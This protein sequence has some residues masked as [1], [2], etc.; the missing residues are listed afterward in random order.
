MNLIESS[1]DVTTAKRAS[2][3]PVFNVSYPGYV[4]LIIYDPANS[5]RVDGKINSKSV[6][7]LLDTGAAVSL[8][9]KDIWDSL[10]LAVDL[11]TWSS[12][13]QLVGVDGSPLPVCGCTQIMLQLGGAVEYAVQIIVIKSLTPGAILGLDF[14]RNNSCVIDIAERLQ[15]KHLKEEELY[16]RKY[17]DLPCRKER[18]CGCL[19]QQCQEETLVNFI[20]PGPDHT[21]F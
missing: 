15:T 1:F 8:I 6:S 2:A 4:V 20:V 21:K 7:F 12:D 17:M 19:L 13:A 14:L 5:F 3:H 18:K 16:N 9:R 10:G 11:T